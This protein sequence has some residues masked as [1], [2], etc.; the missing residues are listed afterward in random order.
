MTAEEWNRLSDVEQ[1]R[2]NMAHAAGQRFALGVEKAL[3]RCGQAARIAPVY[4]RC[5]CTYAFWL[6][7]WRGARYWTLRRRCPSSH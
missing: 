4:A 3:D 2:L 5:V 7:V 1:H 6:G